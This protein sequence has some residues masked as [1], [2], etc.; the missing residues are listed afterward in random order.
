MQRVTEITANEKEVER[1]KFSNPIFSKKPVSIEQALIWGEKD[2]FYSVINPN[3]P[4]DELQEDSNGL[5]KEIVGLN[6]INIDYDNDQCSL[7]LFRNWTHN[8]R[9]QFAKF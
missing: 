5:S 6:V 1:E 7:I 9:Y 3:V 4:N 2:R 8:F